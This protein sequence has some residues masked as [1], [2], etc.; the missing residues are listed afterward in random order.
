MLSAGGA[1]IFKRRL[2]ALCSDVFETSQLSKHL[3]NLATIDA[4]R[5][6][7]YPSCAY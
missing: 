7:D 2:L 4:L 1:D 6:I 3:Q 5:D